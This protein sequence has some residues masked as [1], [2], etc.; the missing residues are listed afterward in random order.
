MS[1]AA[2]YCFLTY[3]PFCRL[4]FTPIFVSLGDISTEEE[5]NIF[6]KPNVV[7]K[8]VWCECCPTD[9]GGQDEEGSNSD[10]KVWGSPE[11]P[12]SRNISPQRGGPA[13][14]LGDPGTLQSLVY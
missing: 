7:A 5:Q 6:P 12:G 13:Q 11:G 4:T 8:G 3:L 1:K 10:C 9:G 14:A 2:V